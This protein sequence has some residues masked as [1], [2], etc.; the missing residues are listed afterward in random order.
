MTVRE[1]AKRPT[2]TLKNLNMLHPSKPLNL[3]PAYIS[4]SIRTSLVSA[5]CQKQERDMVMA[6]T[7]QENSHLKYSV[8]KFCVG[9][10]F[11]TGR[12]QNNSS[13]MY[14]SSKNNIVWNVSF[15]RPAFL[16]YWHRSPLC[17]AAGMSV[18][19]SL[20]QTKRSSLVL[21]DHARLYKLQDVQLGFLLCPVLFL[22]TFPSLIPMGLYLSWVASD[23]TA[24]HFWKEIAQ[25]GQCPLPH[26]VNWGQILI[27]L[28][29]TKL[30][31]TTL[32][33]KW[34]PICTFACHWDCTL[35]GLL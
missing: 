3:D 5:N 25:S 7:C 28:R 33:E 15:S 20:L 23:Y 8:I 19:F 17:Y 16:L 1:A 18:N 32:S 29:D 13:I 31:H 34:I 27:I 35:K 21:G 4:A 2:A 14:R 22:F 9:E 24:G 6:T 11:L 10:V 12:A 26:P 30:I